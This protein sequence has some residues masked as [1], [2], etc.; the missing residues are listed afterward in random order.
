[1]QYTKNEKK[2]LDKATKVLALNLVG[3][4]KTKEILKNINAGGDGTMLAV[5]DMINEEKRQRKIE[6]E[7][8]W[9]DGK[10]EGK[11]EG[12]IQA[13]IHYIK[14]MLKEKLPIDLISRITG[15]SEEEIEKYT[16]LK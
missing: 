9:N 10:A 4:E 12:K 6:L 7:K 2:F 15:V 16:K 1:M 14:N 13:K 5:I 8:R 3:E 11:A